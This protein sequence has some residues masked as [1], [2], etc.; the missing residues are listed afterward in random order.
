MYLVKSFTS[1]SITINFPDAYVCMCVCRLILDIDLFGCSKLISYYS[2][3]H[4][5]MVLMC[6]VASVHTLLMCLLAKIE[7]VYVG[8]RM[9]NKM[10]KRNKGTMHRPKQIIC[11]KTSTEILNVFLFNGMPYKHRQTT[12]SC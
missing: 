5:V 8:R 2:F 7:F 11:H 12:L 10:K 1:K 3:T 4:F 6:P 9:A